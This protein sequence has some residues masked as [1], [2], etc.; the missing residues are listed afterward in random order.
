[1]VARKARGTRPQEIADDLLQTF[2]IPPQWT[3]ENV[4][5]DGVLHKVKYLLWL[6]MNNLKI[7]RFVLNAKY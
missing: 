6:H 4:L 5:A 3:V 1:M 7:L 2:S